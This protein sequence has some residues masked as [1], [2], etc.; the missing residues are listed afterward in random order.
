MKFIPQCPGI[1]TDARIAKHNGVLLRREAIMSK[2][3]DDRSIRL[4]GSVGI[5]FDLHRQ[6][7]T[8]TGRLKVQ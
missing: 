4:I 7:Q 3:T 1:F 6:T 5:G 8:N 2:I